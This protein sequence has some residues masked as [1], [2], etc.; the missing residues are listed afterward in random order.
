MNSYWRELLIETGL[1]E[2]RASWATGFLM[3]AGIGVVAGA[4]TAALLTP[5][6]GVEMRSQLSSR[7]QDLKD[8]AQRALSDAS[9]RT[10][11]VVT[12]AISRGEDHHTRNN[13]APMS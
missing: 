2:R 7:A 6:T 1:I 8:R 9:E 12:N 13:L 4:V 3:G 10:Q 11:Q 5:S